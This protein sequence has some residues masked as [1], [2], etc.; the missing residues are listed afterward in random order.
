ML[1]SKTSSYDALPYP[2]LPFAQSHPGRL[3]TMGQIF[4]LDSPDI[5]DCRV[6]EIGCATG[7]NLVP[8]A[9]QLPGSRFVGFD[10]SQRQ[11]DEAKSWIAELGIKN[12]EVMQLDVADAHPQLGEFDYILCHGVFSWVPVAT[13]NSIMELVA[14]HLSPNGIGYISYNTKPGW[15][16]RGLVRDMMRFHAH[17][18]ESPTDKITRARDWL[19]YM[20][21]NISPIDPFG[22]MIRNELE[23]L[24]GKSEQYLIHEYFEDANNPVYFHQFVSSLESNKLRYLCEADAES[25]FHAE[26][27]NDVMKTLERISGDE[28]RLE[29]HLDFLR[30][31]TFRQSL[32]CH[33]GRPLHRTL[34]PNVVDRFFL[35]P[36]LLPTHSSVHFRNRF[37][38]ITLAI[39]D[40]V[41]HSSLSIL[42][43]LDRSDWRFSELVDEV[44]RRTSRAIEEDALRRMFLQAFASGHMAFHTVRPRYSYDLSGRPRAT[45][46][47][48]AQ[49]VLGTNVTSLS[50]HNV[51]LTDLDR[52]VLQSLDGE[53][54]ISDLPLKV[55]ALIIE[56]TIDSIELSKLQE[57]IDVSL[58]NLAR[59]RLILRAD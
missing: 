5:R 36:L 29:Q 52:L 56:R 2:R 30:N 46:S 11:V 6:L 22:M 51:V 26:L 55:R 43:E 50:H 47:A 31:R 10:L 32:I 37:N 1:E 21:Q 20:V 59:L 9:E 44:K 16:V 54:T 17:G 19:S 48:C 35:E 34:E 53:T 27:P 8:M 23:V 49:S 42:A 12:V 24:K 3:A 57:A 58:R 13:Q 7:G 14:N 15:C 40:P 4:G 45:R 33:E 41:L 28:L 39:D 38:G 18:I 25:T